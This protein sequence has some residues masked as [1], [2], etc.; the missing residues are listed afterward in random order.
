RLT[1]SI[2]TGSLFIILVSIL[3]YFEKNFF[4][5][6]NILLTYAPVFSNISKTTGATVPIFELDLTI[7]NTIIL[8]HNWLKSV[9]PFESY[10][11]HG[12]TDRRTD[13][14]T[15]RNTSSESS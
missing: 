4:F 10:R 3:F 2:A 15:K 14:Q 9:Y 6:K 11:A 13:G 12:R 7:F 5:C 8:S 1:V